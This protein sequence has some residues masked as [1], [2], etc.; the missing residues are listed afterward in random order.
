MTFLEIQDAVMD[1]LNLTSDDARERVKNTINRKYREVQSSVRMD[2]TRRTTVS[3]QT[4]SGVSTMVVSGAKIF[5]VYD[6]DNLKTTLGQVSLTQLRNMDA[7]QEV[8]GIPYIWAEANRVAEST[9]I[10]LFPQP[11]AA[12]WLYFDVLDNATDL[13][14]DADEP[15]FPADFHDIL[16]EAARYEELR[17]M[18]KMMPLAQESFGRFKERMSDLRYFLAK[19]A[20]LKQKTYDS[21]ADYGLSAKIWPYANMG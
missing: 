7:P 13:S 16:V 17:K 4:A 15:T 20:Y 14:D 8:V 5:D 19:S 12:N 1:S 21:Y 10:E 11:T 2:L 18:D 9:T 3:G 6:K